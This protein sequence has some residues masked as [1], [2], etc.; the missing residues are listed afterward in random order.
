M[1][2]AEAHPG[3]PD[4]TRELTPKGR[5]QAE[6][7]GRFLSSVREFD[8]SAGWHS[9]LVRAQQTAALV[10]HQL[11]S[12]LDW[13]SRPGLAPEDDPS[14]IMEAVA[15]LEPNLLLVGHEPN[16][17]SLARMLLGTPDLQLDFKKSAI[18]C[19]ERRDLYTGLGQH[20]AEWSLR[21][22]V[23]LRLLRDMED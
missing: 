22:F 16:L 10:D 6:C 13:Q 5:K 21:W 2:H 1:R 20:R 3:V 11:R 9:N 17:S 23:L 15:K 7:A 18:L 19:L 14:P 4:T 8:A 12:P